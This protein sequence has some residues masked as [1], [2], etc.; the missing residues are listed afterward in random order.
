MRVPCYAH[1]LL[2]AAVLL[3]G[4]VALEVG[5]SQ[6][7]IVTGC[8]SEDDAA[9]PIRERFTQTS[10]GYGELVTLVSCPCPEVLLGWG[11]GV[12]A[13]AYLCPCPCP[14]PCM[15]AGVRGRRSV[16]PASCQLRLQ[17]AEAENLYQVD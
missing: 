16:E 4:A 8:L 13:P 1:W 5:K 2:V 11:S 6:P 14:C 3:P 12:K 15:R 17:R 10:P 9:F 7:C